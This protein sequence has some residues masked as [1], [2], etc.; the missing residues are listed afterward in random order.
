[1]KNTNV[2]I[3]SLI[4]VPELRNFYSQPSIDE[5]IESIENDGLKN[6]ITVTNDF[7]VIDG[8][9]R[10]D[11]VKVLGNDSIDV[12]FTD[13]DADINQRIIRNMY[14]NKTS[15]DKVKELKLIFLEY[16]KKP[17]KKN[18]GLSRKEI[19]SKALDGKCKDESTQNKLEYILNNDLNDEFLSKQIVEKKSDIQNCYMFLTEYIHLDKEKNYGYTEKILNGEISVS[20]ANKFIQG[21]L[22]LETYQDTF[23]IPEKCHSYNI[24]C[25]DITKLKDHIDTVDLIFTSP[26]YYILRN[27]QNSKVDYKNQ[28]GQEESK[29]Q[30]CERIADI[31]NSL[32]PTLKRSANVIINIGETYDDGIA[33]GIPQL[34]KQK[35]ESRS[36]LIYKDSIIWSKP[37]PKPQN[38]SIKRLINNVEY[39]LWFV[40]DPKEAK[41]NLLTYT[42]KAK[43]IKV[44]K[45][46]KDVDSTGKVWANNLSLTKPYQKFKTHLEEQEVFNIIKCKIGKNYDVYKIHQEGHPA[47]MSELLPLVPILMT[48]DE[49]NTV[50]DA[51][52]G[53]NVVG[54]IS[55]LLN[56]R[57]LSTELSKEFYN[58]G[59][60]MLELSVKDFDENSLDKIQQEIYKNGELNNISNAA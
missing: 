2:K 47:I 15:S 1:M 44:S 52:S 29:D 6:P 60:R 26:P 45:G 53:S 3:T 22:N 49:G 13:D 56:R 36:S 50:F 32:I 28:Y 46:A 59:C 31:I 19:V 5:L 42:T 17:G 57:S 8:Y 18:I 40:V 25:T 41:Y 7:K 54:R 48:T 23:I 20:D 38:E 14:R 27:Y 10:I 4:E 16:P 24:D 43:D 39:L 55:Q 12:V 58:I 37:N 33:L 9:R 30:Y 51:F 35:I 34:L 11:A 21:R